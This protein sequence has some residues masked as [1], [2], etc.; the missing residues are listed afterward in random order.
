[1]N[2]EKVPFLK[3]IHDTILPNALSIGVDYDLFW[4]LNPKSLEPFVK[5]FSL[6]EKHA[7][8][9]AWL[10]GKYIQMAVGSTLSKEVK[11][12][13]KPFLESVDIEKSIVMTEEERKLKEME[14]MK[15]R[16][17][18]HVV[19]INANMKKGG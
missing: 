13:S 11:Y 15:A 17:L 10:Q 12:P 18:A 9:L 2:Q 8:Y 14:N 6:K 19:K 7:D 5:A 4:S 3:E 1:M 16:I